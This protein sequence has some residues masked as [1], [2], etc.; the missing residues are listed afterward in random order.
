MAEGDADTSSRN[1]MNIGTLISAP[2]GAGINA[3]TILKRIHALCTW[4][5]VSSQRHK[6]FAI[7][8]HS[9]QPKLHAKKIQVIDIDVLT[10]VT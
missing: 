5:Q 9:C 2:D 8:V 1:Q 7:N 4:V 10:V 6:K 3:H